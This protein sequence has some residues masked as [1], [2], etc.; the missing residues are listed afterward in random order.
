MNRL[1]HTD[2]KGAAR[3]VDISAKPVSPREAKAEG[4]VVLAAE[5]L[6]LIL[7]GE[8]KK[9]DVL[10]IARLAGIQAAKKTADLIPL[11]HTLLLHNV[12]VDITPEDGKLAVRAHVRLDGQTGAEMEAL[13]AV[14]IACLT[15]YDMAKAADRAMR[16]EGIRL[17]HKSGGKSG[18]FEAD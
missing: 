18:V 17:L 9:G 8:N 16:I 7:A 6:R 5:T 1:S 10:T 4:Y 12:A 14:S 3:M 15:I 13:T 2:K 11:C